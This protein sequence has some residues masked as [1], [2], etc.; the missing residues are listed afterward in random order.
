MIRW[1]QQTM[2]AGERTNIEIDVETWR[3]LNGKKQPGD[4]FDDVLR[5][6][7]DGLDTDE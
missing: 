6:E 2:P 5:R 4:S 7:L 3:Y 1:M